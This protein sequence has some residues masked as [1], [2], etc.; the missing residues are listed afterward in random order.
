MADITQ[1]KLPSGDTYDIKDSVARSSTLTV[2]YTAATL[3]LE[4]GFTNITEDVDNEE[5]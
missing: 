2:S 1:I 5:F 3:D 4:L